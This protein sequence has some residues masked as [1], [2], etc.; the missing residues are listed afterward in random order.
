[1]LSTNVSRNK[2]KP[3]PAQKALSIRSSSL[4][5]YELSFY[6]HIYSGA[7]VQRS[8]ISI[9][10]PHSSDSE[11]VR[12]WMGKEKGNLNENKN[13]R[14]SSWRWQESRKTLKLYWSGQA[15]TSIYTNDASCNVFFCKWAVLWGNMHAD[16][17]W[18]NNQSLDFVI[19][20][21]LLI[22]DLL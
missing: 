22:A 6:Y 4:S 18:S 13:K 10:K 14:L 16:R 12:E 17:P 19:L 2:S 21:S 20:T 11:I 9:K 1:M 7:W 15:K 5:L 8:L 3:P